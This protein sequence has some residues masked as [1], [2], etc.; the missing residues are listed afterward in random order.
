MPSSHP[1]AQVTL[2]SGGDLASSEVRHPRFLIECITSSAHNVVHLIRTTYRANNL[3][4]REVRRARSGPGLWPGPRRQARWAG[5]GSRVKGLPEGTRPEGAPLTLEGP[6]QTMRGAPVLALRQFTACGAPG[7]TLTAWARCW[8]A[9][10]RDTA[11]HPGRSFPLIC[12]RPILAVHSRG[13]QARRAEGA[14]LMLVKKILTASTW[15]PSSR[16]DASLA[17]TARGSRIAP[18]WFG[19]SGRRRSPTRRRRHERVQSVVPGRVD[20]GLVPWAAVVLDFDPGIVARADD[21]ADG[22]D[23]AGKAGAAVLGG[24]GGEFGGAQDHVI[25]PQAAVED[26]AQVSTDGADVLGAAGIG[27]LGGALPKYPGCW[28]VHGSSLQRL[29]HGLCIPERTLYLSDV[30]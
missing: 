6:A 16:P 11:G 29:V 8:R 1:V 23:A 24:V 2:Y 30:Q 17:T 9:R 22:E 20:H 21:G 10:Q 14:P 7:A 27:D 28:R 15:R 13:R 26:G 25:C 3:V 4:R 5:R 19:W 12:S 18:R